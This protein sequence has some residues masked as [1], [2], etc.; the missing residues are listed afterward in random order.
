MVAHDDTDISPS[1]RNAM[2]RVP[3]AEF[4][5]QRYRWEA[6]ADRPVPIG[7]GQTI[8]QPRIVATMTELAGVGP[9][10]RVLEIGTGSGYQA[11]VLAEMGAEVYSVEVLPSLAARARDVLERLG[12]GDRV[13]LRVGDG[14]KG[15]PEQAPFDAIVVT[16]APERLP[17]E[18]PEQ[19]ADGGR[20]V[21]PIG[22]LDQMLE[23]IVRKGDTFQRRAL[24]PV[25]FVP[26]VA[27]RS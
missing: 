8:S 15:W 25:R 16:A 6:D 7:E 2:A 22:E 21:I 1:V 26:L 18:L 9:G 10:D 17:D 19:L 24:L 3:R 5:P 27:T 20:L 4:I 13:H 12:Y 14:R 23:L 11:A